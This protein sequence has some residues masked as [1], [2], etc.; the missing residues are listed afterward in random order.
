MYI[1]HSITSGCLWCP[2][3]CQDTQGLKSPRIVNAGFQL[4][5]NKKLKGTRM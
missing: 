4:L 3:K 1:S 2:S 5:K